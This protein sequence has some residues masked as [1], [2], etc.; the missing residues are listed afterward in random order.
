V[1]NIAPPN[2]L[3]RTNS[4]RLKEM[5]TLR[6]SNNVDPKRSPS[7]RAVSFRS[8]SSPRPA[9]E[10]LIFGGEDEERRKFFDTTSREV[11]VSFPWL[12]LLDIDL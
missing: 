11:F 4:Y 7:L 12:G 1:G 9:S 8:G 10:H 6:R 2:P 3:T 5:N